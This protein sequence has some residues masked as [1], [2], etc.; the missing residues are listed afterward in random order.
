M[1]KLFRLF[2]FFSLCTASIQAYDNRS[3]SGLEVIKKERTSS[4]EQVSIAGFNEEEAIALDCLYAEE[5]DDTCD[6]QAKKR[7][8]RRHHHRR[9]HHKRS[10]RDRNR[11]ECPA[12][13]AFTPL[14]EPIEITITLTIPQL[15]GI[16]PIDGNLDIT[17]FAIGPN[18]KFYRGAVTNI[19]PSSALIQPL[20]TV[21]ISDPVEGNYVVGYFVALG[22]NSPT[23]PPSAIANFSG[24]I[25]NNTVGGF[26]QTI[27]FPVQTLFIGSLAGEND[28]LTVTANFPVAQS[29]NQP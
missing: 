29:L 3:F 23:F 10:H 8:H 20:N 11:C 16:I 9:H 14:E 26:D 2:V 19:I 13:F 12:S 4:E 18:G 24:V 1:N 5:C 15:I 27:T 22:E 6:Q 21:V 17:P 25:L 28:L 7:P